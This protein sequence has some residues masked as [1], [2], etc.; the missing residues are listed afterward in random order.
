MYTMSAVDYA[1]L[2]KWSKSPEAKQRF[3]AAKAQALSE[4]QKRFPCADAS[5]FEEEVEVDPKT[6]KA[7][8]TVLFT[9]SDGFA[10][11]RG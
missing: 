3:K 11:G 1:A 2:L 10:D 6:R 5:Q 4:F 9:E 7:T 8:A